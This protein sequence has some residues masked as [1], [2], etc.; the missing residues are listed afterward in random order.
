VFRV[1]LPQ[2]VVFL[3]WDMQA[4][5][6]LPTEGCQEAPAHPSGLSE[7]RPQPEGLA[8]SSIGYRHATD[9]APAHECSILSRDEHNTAE[10]RLTC[11]WQN[12]SSREASLS[13][14]QRTHPFTSSCLHKLPTHSS[15]QLEAPCL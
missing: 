5:D 4:R 11:Q 7:A 8:L 13:C 10:H 6:H 3:P 15:M 9:S 12:L 2:P 14:S 1:G